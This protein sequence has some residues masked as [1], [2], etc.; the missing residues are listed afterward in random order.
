MQ[1]YI[2]LWV[3]AYLHSTISVSTWIFQS[4][5]SKYQTTF[6][7]QQHWRTHSIRGETF[8]WTDMFVLIARLGRGGPGNPKMTDNLF[9]PC[10]L[11]WPASGRGEAN[12]HTLTYTH[13]QQ[14]RVCRRALQGVWETRKRLF[15][16][17]CSNCDYMTTAVSHSHHWQW[18]FLLDQLIWV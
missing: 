3:S 17:L 2:E 8:L 9:W 16:P 15:F 11:P 12:S 7:Q 1:M 13:K 10:V 4:T 14:I 6:L 5:S 18:G